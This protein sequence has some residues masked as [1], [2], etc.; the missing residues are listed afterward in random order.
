MRRRTEFKPCRPSCECLRSVA[1]APRCQ[2]TPERRASRPAPAGTSTAA[3]RDRR[4][5]AA[6][7]WPRQ[8]TVAWA[9]TVHV[10]QGRTVDAVIA[11]MEANHPH[12][13]T[14]KSFYVE[15][16]RARDRAEIVTDDR[17]A[18]REQLEAVT[19]ER[20]AALEAVE[21]ERVKGWEAGL[22]E[23]R[24]APALWRPR[25]YRPAPRA[26]RGRE[27]ACR[28]HTLLPGRP[29]VPRRR[30]R[31]GRPDR[32]G[33]SRASATGRSPG[34][35]LPRRST[36]RCQHSMAKRGNQIAVTLRMSGSRRPGI[37]RTL[38]RVSKG[39]L[40][41]RGRSPE[42]PP[43][44][45]WTGRCLKPDVGG[46]D[47]GGRSRRWAAATATGTVPPASAAS[48]AREGR[49]HADPRGADRHASARA[50]R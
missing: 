41:P 2:P 49:R 23:G 30:W 45:Q 29:L 1:K 16:S 18:L 34:S 42:P 22:D 9:A 10:F 14:Q 40:R 44:R 46:P 36:R 11:A 5:P 17:V 39:T 33:P 8:C 50:R 35:A 48:P 43:Y 4:L 31:P 21:P 25:R 13:T 12:L 19:G 28:R 6:Q 32:G 26:V 27:R 38:R 24:V 15:F 47:H 3:R 7:P 37:G 20:V